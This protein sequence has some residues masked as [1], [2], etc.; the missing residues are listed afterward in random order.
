MSE[1][2]ESRESSEQ[3]DKSDTTEPSD[4]EMLPDKP[5]S[6]KTV[7]FLDGEKSTPQPK[8]PGEPK[9]KD[10]LAPEIYEPKDVKPSKPDEGAQST[11][12]KNPEK[13][14]KQKAQGKSSTFHMKRTPC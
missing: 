2:G 12:P 1:S 7:H 14:D 4:E 10:G 8:E 11:G 3:R 5:L 13:T 6:G 9:E